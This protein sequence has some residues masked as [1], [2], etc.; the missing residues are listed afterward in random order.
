MITAALLGAFLATGSASAADVSSPAAPHTAAH[1]ADEKVT[2][3]LRDADLTNVLGNLATLLGVTPIIA[4]GVSGRV[5]M[6]ANA[7]IRELLRSLEHDFQITIRIADGRMLVSRA[8]TSTATLGDAAAER[9]YLSDQALPRRP[10]A[11]APKRFEGAVEIRTLTG[12]TASY[13]L[14]APGRITVPGCKPGLA[15]LP[16][17]GDRFDGLPS[18]VLTE[19]DSLPRVL[20]PSLQEST[21]L[22]VPG[23]SASL[24][25]KLR[26]PNG[27]AVAPEPLPPFG[28]FRFQLRVLEVGPGGE[29]VLSAARVLVAGGEAAMV[30]SGSAPGSSTGVTPGQTFQAAFVIVDASGKDATLAVSSSVLRDV[31]PGDG[32]RVLT[33]RTAHARESA[34]LT[35]GKNQRFVFSPTYGRG[36]SALVLDVVLERA[37]EAR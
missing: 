1:A 9:R 17:P 30:Q 5:T 12:E 13:L 24:S 23:C 15:I 14:S 29:T 18:L 3:N 28:M 6:V 33:I 2:L 8:D 16:L 36:D 26:T 4:P 19:E 25:L 34:R 31:D 11:D 7:P 10:A 37:A 21:V 35:F 22:D 20:S 27:G 32:G